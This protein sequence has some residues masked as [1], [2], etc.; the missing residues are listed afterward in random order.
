MHVTDTAH[1]NPA[2]L[3]PAF[4]G[5]EEEDEDENEEDADQMMGSAMHCKQIGDMRAA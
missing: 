1:G 3:G 2:G 4:E 5:G